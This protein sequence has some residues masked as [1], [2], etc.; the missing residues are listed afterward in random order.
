MKDRLRQALFQSDASLRPDPAARTPSVQL[1]PMVT[2]APDHA[3]ADLCEQLNRSAT[4]YPSTS[5]R[6][7]YETLS[8]TASQLI[9]GTAES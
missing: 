5:L 4:S 8:A 7:V 3:V 1:L 6:L 2:H 9:A